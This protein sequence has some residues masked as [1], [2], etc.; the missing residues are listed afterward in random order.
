MAILYLKNLLPVKAYNRIIK[1]HIKI[2]PPYNE[3]HGLVSQRLI[4]RC[5]KL[6][7]KC[8][9]GRIRTFEISCTRSMYVDRTTP[10]PARSCSTY[11][12]ITQWT[13]PKRFCFVG[14]SGIEPET[15]ASQMPRATNCATPR[16]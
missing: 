9:G 8:L 5:R 13:S 4:I 11:A 12:Y 14:V 6:P 3:V 1:T 16:I 15:S 10:R 2:L 7:L